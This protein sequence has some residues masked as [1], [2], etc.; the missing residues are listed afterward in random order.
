MPE[1]KQKILKL[2]FD[3]DL[4]FL[5][6]GILSGARDYKLC[7][8]INRKLN[9]DLT[10]LDDLSISTGRPGSQTKH[11][12]FVANSKG[13]E[14]YY[15]L[16]NRDSENTGSFIPEMRNVDFF[17]LVSGMAAN[18]KIRKTVEDLRLI[19]VVSG[20]FEIDPDGLKSAETF[21]CLLEN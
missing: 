13:V 6:V 8:E 19:D 7:F 9:L 3:Q 2:D 11:A 18:F 1:E 10:R 4:D 17:L 5:L 14:R 20:A 21:L 15:L 16:S 12:R